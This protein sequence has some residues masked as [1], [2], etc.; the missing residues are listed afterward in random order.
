MNLCMCISMQE[1]QAPGWAS[2]RFSTIKTQAFSGSQ[3][4]VRG[5]RDSTLMDETKGVLNVGVT[6]GV[7][8]RVVED[9]R[10]RSSL[11]MRPTNGCT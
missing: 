3:Y 8:D 10:G 6:K 2:P 7:Q 11:C 4:R 1:F 9:D 5:Q